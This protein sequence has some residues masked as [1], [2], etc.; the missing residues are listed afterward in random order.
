MKIKWE[1]IDQNHSDYLYRAEI[2][3]GWLVKNGYPLNES[4]VYSITF[5]PDKNHAW[6]SL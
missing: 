2:E 3:G 1:Q 5:V 4:Y 6:A